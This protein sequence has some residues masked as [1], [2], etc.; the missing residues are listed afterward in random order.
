VNDLVSLVQI[1]LVLAATALPIAGAIR[2]LAGDEDQL[3]STT[4][5]HLPW[6]RGIQEDEPQPWRI[7]PAMG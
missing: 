2:L 1:V 5:S 6:P 7:R 4:P 3:A